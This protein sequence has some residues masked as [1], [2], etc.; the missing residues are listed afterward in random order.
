MKDLIRDQFCKS[1]ASGAGINGNEKAP[2]YAGAPI[3]SGGLSR[4]LPKKI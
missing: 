4:K 3:L 1:Y 2:L